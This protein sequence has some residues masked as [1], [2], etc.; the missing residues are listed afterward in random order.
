[1]DLEELQSGVPV[2]AWVA[3]LVVC[4]AGYVG[5]SLLF[6][7][8]TSSNKIRYPPM[9]PGG[10]WFVLQKFWDV[11]I[12]D[13]M[14]E[15]HQTVGKVVELPLAPPGQHVFL[16]G[17]YRVC[18]KILENPK[19]RKCVAIYS[20]FDAVSSGP[21]FFTS[22]GHRFKHARKATNPAFAALYVEDMAKLAD[23][24][25][26]DW[27]RS[28][29]ASSSEV[30]LDVG[31]EMRRLTIQVIAQVAFDYTLTE[32]ET[33]D[34]LDALDRSNREFVIMTQKYPFRKWLPWFIPAVRQA[35]RDTK[36]IANLNVKMLQHFRQKK[37]PARD[38]VLYQIVN[39]PEYKSDKERTCDMMAYLGAGF[40]TTSSS[41]NWTVLELAKNPTIQTW[42]RKELRSL[43]VDKR[44]SCPA[45]LRVIKESLRK[46]PPAGI[47]SVS[48]TAQDI[49]F[50]DGITTIPKRSTVF[51]SFLGIHHDADV[52]EKPDAFL[53]SRWENP[54]PEMQRS[55]LP[56][57]AG[58]RNCQGQALANA[59]LQVVLARLCSDYEWAVAKEGRRELYGTMKSMGTILKA[60]KL[61]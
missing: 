56:F 59:E 57:A 9:A 42:L 10:F 58:R 27:I 51:H 26:M 30:E 5:Y 46:H 38:T 23:K 32:R 54:T 48:E 1:M 7:K 60:T 41:I 45:L 8:S 13:Y 14:L 21:T 6:L 33:A 36:T 47:A 40:D 20:Q 11:T 4:S 28:T 22:E 37:D 17:D 49:V 55:Y 43:P 61:S 15:L 16:V 29:F 44:R 24:K 18:R 35:Y 19:T 25:V 34:V 50:E 2:W 12:P 53:P 3:I 52:F 39:N 31:L